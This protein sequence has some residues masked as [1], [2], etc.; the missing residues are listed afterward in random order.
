M[1]IEP[2]LYWWD[3]LAYELVEVTDPAQLDDRDPLTD[4]PIWAATGQ[5]TGAAEEWSNGRHIGWLIRAY[6]YAEAE[7]SLRLCLAE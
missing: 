7:A 3:E 6:S 2:K 5:R 4:E 1:T